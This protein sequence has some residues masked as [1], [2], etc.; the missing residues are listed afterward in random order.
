MQP[1]CNRSVATVIACLLVLCFSLP[2]L[3]QADAVLEQWRIEVG[4]GRG[5]AENDPQQAL[6]DARRLQANIPAEALLGDKARLLNLLSRCEI[7]LAQ[8]DDAEK[9]ARLALEMATK[10]EDKAG[11]VEALLNVALNA[12][13]QAKIET[14]MAATIRSVELLDGINRPDLSGE[15]MLRMAMMYRRQGDF[16]NSL[17]MA[18][19]AIE[20][21]QRNGNSL[22]LAFAHQGMAIAFEQSHRYEDAREHY[23]KMGEQARAAHS[24]MLEAFAFQG[25]G[26]MT[27]R[28]GN[29]AAGE[30]LVREAIDMHRK[31][32]TPFGLNFGLYALADLLREQERYALEHTL[33]TEIIA[34]YDK[35]P[36]QI[37]LWFALNARST[38]LQALHRIDAAKA[39]AERAYT[40]AKEIGFPLYLGE[41][42]KRMAA[43][44]AATG[45][46]Q[47]AY[48]LSAEAAKQTE[49]AAIDKNSKRL[50]ELTQRY[51]VESKQRKIS[52]LTLHNEQQANRQRWLWTILGGSLALLGIT[53]F[54]LFRLRRSREE[55]RELNV[56]LEQRVQDRTAEL[57]QQARYLRTLLNML[58]MWAWL[59]D[60][61]SNYL[62]VNQATADACG[63]TVEEMQ[64]KSDLDILPPDI[65]RR[66]HADDVEVMVS[67]QRKTAEERREGEGG[68]VVWME[69]YKAAVLDDDG[70]V[71]GTVGVARDI[72]ERKTTEAAHEAALAEA[73]RLARSR[74]EF[75]AQMSHELRTPLNGILGY[76][77]ILG[78]D[79]KLNER[80]LAGVN[81]IQQSG[82]HLLTLINDILDFAKIDAGKMELNP[83]DIPLEK[84]LRAIVSIMRV[85]ADEKSLEFVF[86][87]APD[88]PAWIKVDEKRLRQVL[89]NLLSNA[90]KFTEHGRV[91]LLVKYAQPGILR[92]EVQD[93]GIGIESELLETIFQPFEQVGSM[94]HQLG[95]TG[96]GLP[97]SRQFVRLMGSDIQVKSRL[98]LGSSFWFDLETQSQSTGELALTPEHTATG[99]AGERK[100]ILVV[101]DVAENRAVAVQMLEPLG[102]NMIE[103]VDGG[104]GLEKARTLRP[105]LILMDTVMPGVGGLEATRRLRQLPGL[106]DIP[107]IGVSASATSGDEAQSLSAGVNAFLSKPLDLTRLLAQIGLLLKLDWVYESGVTVAQGNEPIAVPPLQELETLHHLAQIGNM[108]DILQHCSYLIETGEEY[109]PFVEQLRTMA[110]SYQT[111]AIVGFIQKHLEGNGKHESNI[112]H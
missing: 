36:N 69:T 84:F 1:L 76:A 101:D 105:D 59:K 67:H 52:E 4:R 43:L 32:R 3:A 106:Q 88:L 34:N 70:T 50:V 112:V 94:R 91:S 16:E 109:R 21:A 104:D 87:M 92:F 2:G 29:M 22:A 54:F 20:I 10:Q 25:Q 23:I 9:H 15:A 100:T 46:Y 68:Q 90:F 97:I 63:R 53:A 82:E 5:L 60:T 98:G 39:D 83:V 35:Y 71:L 58:P 110:L 99:Y 81:V 77:Q 19:Q 64:G 56:G 14:A 40:L 103:A 96:L 72:S 55:I 37:G 108:R 11:Q 49:S 44:A 27:V 28:T 61:K 80:Q 111:R 57:R 18:M 62:A 89:L 93:T 26:L 45:E 31:L 30:T 41:S 47:R 7:Y 78:R 38:N 17:T 51:A 6:A 13:N 33:L 75:L 12:I 107:V 85:K 65:A 73:E 66:H 86:S 95:G 74:S 102:F 8:T 79:K 48:Q 42:A 24:K